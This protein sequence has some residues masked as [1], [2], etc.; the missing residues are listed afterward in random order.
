M[1]RQNPAFRYSLH[2]QL[3]TRYREC[4]VSLS[5]LVLR[6]FGLRDFP[7]HI[8][9]QAKETGTSIEDSGQA[10]TAV[11]FYVPLEILEPPIDLDPAFA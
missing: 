8:Y 10:G 11:V 4:R 2:M 1:S 9:F 5:C 6:D 7:D 3:V